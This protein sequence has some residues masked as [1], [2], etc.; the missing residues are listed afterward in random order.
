MWA[1]T[2]TL[3]P[4]NRAPAAHSPDLTMCM[5]DP[6]TFSKIQASP[7]TRVT[8]PHPPATACLQAT[9]GDQRAPQNHQNQDAQRATHNP[10]L[11]SPGMLPAQQLGPL[12]GI[13][14]TQFTA[15]AG[16]NGVTFTINP[17]MWCG[18]DHVSCEL[19][20]G[21]PKRHQQVMGKESGR[22][23]ESV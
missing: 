10:E 19:P 6:V 20:E 9:Q 18:G 3:Q 1:G 2:S 22:P 7:G 5:H 23:R 14:C 15:A 13:S 4:P 21:S 16:P 17:C 8:P 12:H 11:Y